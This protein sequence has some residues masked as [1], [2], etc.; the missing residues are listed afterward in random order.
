MPTIRELLGVLRNTYPR[1]LI[2]SAYYDAK[3]R[4]SDFDI[5][6]PDQI[7]NKVRAMI[8]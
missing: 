7:K 8:G 6:I 5:G 2:R 1:N 4:F 3:E